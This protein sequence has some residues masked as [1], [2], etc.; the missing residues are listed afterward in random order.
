MRPG[1]TDGRR[2]VA[3]QVPWA[4]TTVLPMVP[5]EP[6]SGTGSPSHQKPVG[7]A[8]STAVVVENGL[9]LR[10]HGVGHHVTRPAPGVGSYLPHL[11]HHVGKC[12]RGLSPRE[13]PPRMLWRS[14]SP[15]HCHGK[16]RCERRKMSK[17]GTPL[18]EEI[19]SPV[20]PLHVWR[21]VVSVTFR[22][23]RKAL[24]KAIPML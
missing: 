1:G 11:G 20:H 19:P 5:K 2:S 17:R 12:Q 10:P 13:Q 23:L 18:L 6:A 7:H 3:T 4:V 9:Y 16:T 21:A 15:H 24:S 8:A 14:P 22:W